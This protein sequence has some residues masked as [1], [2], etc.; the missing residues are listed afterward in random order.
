MFRKFTSSIL[1]IRLPQTHIQ[2]I[3]K[4]NSNAI[5]NSVARS[6]SLSAVKNV[7]VQEQAPTFEGKAIV[8]GQIKNISLADFAGKY[9]VLFFYPLD[10]TFVCPTELVSFSDHINAFK[11]IDVNVI[12]C[13]CDSHFSHLA[14]INT[15]RKHGGLGGLA[16]P[17]L[18]DYDKKIAKAYDVLIEPDGIPL[19]GLFI[20]D[21]KGIVRQIT[22][23][24]L[25]VGRSVDE[26]L[27]LVQ[28]FQ[29][30]DKNGEV[31]PMNWKPNSPTIRPD[32]NLAKEYFN[33]VN[34]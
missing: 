3:P 6:F 16:Y 22:I 10:F 21:P 23:N 9:L 4:Y 29:F 28:A 27:R 7:K 13:S 17:L 19:R 34:K 11:E 30:V 33:K 20:I 24:D 12:G 2:N 5:T 26:V 8:D 25:P 14:F 15:P 31:C 32:P 1:S 18:S